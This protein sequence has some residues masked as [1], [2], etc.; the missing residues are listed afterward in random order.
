MSELT[1]GQVVE[2]FHLAFEEKDAAAL[3]GLVADEC[4]LE[5]TQPAPDGQRIE[6]GDACLRFWQGLITDAEGRFESEEI[7]VA[8]DK[9]TMRWNYVWGDGESDHL[10]GVN[11]MRVLDGKIVEALG[12]AKTPAPA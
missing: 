4:V 7:V 9:A 8:G 5:N 6:G 1:T 3:V 2:R 11:L 12:Y 10:R